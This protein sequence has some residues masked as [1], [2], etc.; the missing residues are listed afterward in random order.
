MDMSGM[1]KK[2][3]DGQSG[4]AMGAGEVDHVKNAL[5][6]LVKHMHGKMAEEDGSQSPEEATDESLESL[7]QKAKESIDQVAEGSAQDE[8]EEG[9]KLADAGYE[10]EKL[11]FMRGK[12]PMDA[13]GTVLVKPKR[14]MAPVN[15]KGADSLK[16]A[17][18]S[19]PFKKNKSF[20]K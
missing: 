18:S 20:W 9:P 15:P 10:A 19:K 11:S 5:S 14:P 16:D 4:D 7:G 17:F 3:Y 8:S 12:K 2:K 1:M 6:S 13:E